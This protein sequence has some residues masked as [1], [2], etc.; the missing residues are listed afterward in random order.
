[1]DSSPGPS[2]SSSSSPYST[3][4]SNVSGTG[5][6][7]VFFITGYWPFSSREPDPSEENFDGGEGG[8]LDALNFG[9]GGGGIVRGGGGIPLDSVCTNFFGGGIVEMFLAFESLEYGLRHSDP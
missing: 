6:S 7:L 9:G 2:V 4:F 1:M 8:D 3:S 5:S